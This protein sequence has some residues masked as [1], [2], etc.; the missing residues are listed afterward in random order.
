MLTNLALRSFSLRLFARLAI[1]GLVAFAPTS[2]IEIKAQENA[3]H[4]ERHWVDVEG[5]RFEVADG[6]HL[7]VAAPAELCPRPI[8]A[9][10]DPQGRL[11]VADSSG[12]NAPVQEQLANPTHRILRLIDSD[13]DGRFDT[14]TVFAERMMF[15]EGTLFHDGSLYVSAPPQIWKLTDRDDD[16]VADEREVWFDGKT[17]T[18]CANDLHGPYLGRDGWIYWCKGA[19]DEQHYVD[20]EGRPWTT[21]ASHLFRRHPSGG[22]VESVMAGGMDN[23]VDIVFTRSGE[24]LFTTTFLT[25]PG[26]GQRDGVIHAIY[27][28]L[29]GK[30]HGV[31]E[32]HT[33]TGELMPPLVHLGAA[34]PAGMALI[35]PESWIQNLLPEQAMP[36]RESDPDVIAVACFNLHQVMRVPLLENGATFL[37]DATP[38][39]SGE[40]LDFHPTDIVPDADGSLLVVDTGGWYKLCCPTSQFERPDVLGGIYRLVPNESQVPADPRGL[41]VNFNSLDAEEYSRLIDDP[42]PLVRERCMELVDEIRVGEAAIELALGAD[43]SIVSRRNAVWASSRLGEETRHRLLLKAS[44]DSDPSVL[45]AVAHVASLHRDRGVARQLSAKLASVPA[46]VQRAIFEALGRTGQASDLSTIINVVQQ[47]G[48]QPSPDAQRVLEHSLVFALIEIGRREGG[49]EATREYLHQSLKGDSATARLAALALRELHGDDLLGEVVVQWLES[50]DAK[51][52]ETAEWMLSQP[53]NW[54]ELLKPRVVAGLQQSL[55]RGEP[56]PNWLHRQLENESLQET[57]RV[58]CG[59]QLLVVDRRDALLKLLASLSSRPTMTVCERIKHHVE[60]FSTSEQAEVFRWLLILS[61]EERAGSG[62][63]PAAIKLA[64]NS[65]APVEDRLAA[66]AWSNEG[67]GQLDETLFEKAIADFLVEDWTV[68][69]QAREVLRRGNLNDQQRLRIIE[70][71]DQLPSIRLDRALQAITRGAS[72]EV[73]LKLVERLIEIE[74]DNVLSPSQLKEKLEPLGEV[75]LAAA[76]PLF[77][78]QEQRRAEQVARLEQLEASLPPGDV[79]RGQHLFHADRIGCIRCHQMGYVGGRMGPDL[80]RIGQIRA[81]RDLLEAI[82]FPNAS[83]V[84]SYE[85]WMAETLDGGQFSG[86]MTNQNATE[87]TLAWSPT[88]SVTLTRQDLVELTPSEVSIMPSGFDQQLTEQELADLIEFLK[89]SR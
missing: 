25:H 19:F 88:E 81:Q 28:G 85:P 27:G 12:S 24:R 75:V 87:V 4:G 50:D 1:G 58:W 37:G 44:E 15:P 64:G 79:S 82:V 6:W 65:Q 36:D 68:S 55:E 73:G 56:L 71:L 34:A 72:G 5:R 89:A 39:V 46:S 69:D 33:R 40:S 32:G 60:E 31:I 21:R 26:N 54:T 76:Q 84:R 20:G 42:R 78:D 61:D 52:R 11:Y 23:P 16:G 18:G 43:R 13:N 35:E 22:L 7:E 45:Q 74:A 38:W 51:L 14:S 59:E 29:Y 48:E 67:W 80:T 62:L 57:I 77:A 3:P 30:D 8:T 17:L 41:L 70:V 63:I 2:S 83:F 10:F 86:I 47:L 53:G 9:S 66:A 49:Q